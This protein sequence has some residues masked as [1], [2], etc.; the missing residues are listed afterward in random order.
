MEVKPKETSYGQTFH[1]TP[2]NYFQRWIDVTT[3]RSDA[4]SFH[5]Q[6]WLTKKL[7]ITNDDIRFGLKTLYKKLPMKQELLNLLIGEKKHKLADHLRLLW[8]VQDF[9]EQPFESKLFQLTVGNEFTVPANDASASCYCDSLLVCMFLSTTHFDKCLSVKSLPALWKE[10]IPLEVQQ[11]LIVIVNMMRIKVQK[12]D[13]E[14]Q[15]EF[16]VRKKE[17]PNQIGALITAFINTVKLKE[18]ALVGA[19]AQEDTAL[20]FRGLLYGI[21]GCKPLYL[22]HVWLGSVIKKADGKKEDVFRTE[23]GED[24]TKLY[25]DP[26]KED[27]VDFQAALNGNAHILRELVEVLQISGDTGSIDKYQEE[28]VGWIVEQDLIVIE[29]QGGHEDRFPFPR[30]RFNRG[31]K[32]L[33]YN[34]TFFGKKEPVEYRV[35]S[36]VLKDSTRAIGNTGGHYTAYFRINETGEWTYYSDSPFEL[37]PQ[38]PFISKGITFEDRIRLLFLKKVVTK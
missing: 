18:T 14:T 28:S 33:R 38:H 24:I 20:F 22:H 23:N 2:R 37:I 36:M 21:L 3:H 7:T 17:Y 30:F 13:K 15:K 4:L 9:E 35:I 10:K 8:S 6:P 25:M 19:G 11:P 34:I 32:D 29:P 27:T 31:N 12:E 26:K 1:E 5:I 16:E